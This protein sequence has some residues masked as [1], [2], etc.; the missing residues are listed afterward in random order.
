MRVCVRVCTGVCA[1]MRVGRVGMFACMRLC[2][3]V[4]ACVRACV[5]VLVHAGTQTSE[6]ADQQVRQRGHF[7]AFRLVRGDLSLIAFLE[8]QS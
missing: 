3:S 8:T 5:H 7:K 4:C 1:C 6:R 2:V